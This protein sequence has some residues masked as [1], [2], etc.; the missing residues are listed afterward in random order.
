MAS[1]S[2]SRAL[3]SPLARQLALPAT[4]RRTI[5]SA[6]IY[7]RAGLAA[8]SKPAVTAVLQQTRGIKQVDFAGTTETVYG[9]FAP[10]I[11][12]LV[13]ADSNFQSARTGLGKNYWYVDCSRIVYAA[14][15]EPYLIMHRV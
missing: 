5:N 9:D 7:A 15:Y 14:C 8:P 11:A 2:F 1:R 6:S 12:L 4:Q 3:R 10:S 13:K